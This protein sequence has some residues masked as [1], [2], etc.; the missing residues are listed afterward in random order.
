MIRFEITIQQEAEGVRVNA[1]T[2]PSDATPREVRTAL[3]IM[4]AINES[5]G[6]AAGFKVTKPFSDENRKM[7]EQFIKTSKV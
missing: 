3:A 1:K 2:P 4:D 7:Y 5:T 6:K